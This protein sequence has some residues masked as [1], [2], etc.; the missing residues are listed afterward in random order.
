MAAATLQEFREWRGRYAGEGTCRWLLSALYELRD[1]PRRGDRHL[2]G[3]YYC[4]WRRRVGDLRIIYT[5]S[6]SEALV[7]VVEI[8]WRERCY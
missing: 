5:V 2:E 6:D 1:E 7:I 4:N 3:E 8:C